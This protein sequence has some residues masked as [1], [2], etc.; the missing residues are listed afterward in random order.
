MDSWTVILNGS[1]EILQKGRQPITK[2]LGDSFGVNTTPGKV[3]NKGV[4]KTRID[5]C[6]VD[7]NVYFSELFASEI[8]NLYLSSKDITWETVLEYRT[9]FSRYFSQVVECSRCLPE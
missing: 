2:H 4:M 8:F 3:Y 1:V 5:D 6:Q 7:L 9:E